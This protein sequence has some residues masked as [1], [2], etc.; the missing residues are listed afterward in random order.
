MTKNRIDSIFLLRLFAMLMVVL[1]HVTGQF[2]STLPFDS[3]AFQKYHFINRIV[4]IEAGIFI[5]ITGMVFFFNYMKKNLTWDVLK[6]YYKKRVTFI[7]VPYLIWAVFYEV[8]MYQIGFREVNIME[9]VDRILHGES[10][11]QLHFIF[12]IV[13]FYLVLPLFVYMAQK[14]NFFRKYM[15]AFG[16]GFELLYFY[17]NTTYEITTFHVF[18]N[19]IGTFLLGA[20]IGT[21]YNEMRQKIRSYSSVLLFIAATVAGLAT[22]YLHYDMYML[23]ESTLPGITYKFVNL[24]YMVTGSYLIFRLAELASEKMP[25]RLFGAVKN[26]A[27]YSFGFYLLHPVVLREVAKFIPADPSYM[28]HLQMGLRYVS[29]VIFCYLIIWTVHKFVPGA[30]AIFGKLPK[31]ASFVVPKQSEQKVTM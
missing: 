3:G 31:K 10:Y 6:D 21:Y 5:M 17:L 15:W 29:T 13:Q 12:L 1:V 30:S 16:F 28:F 27:V 20:W 19:S 4:R 8:Y 22:V 24:I 14:L 9:S 2:Q 25:N 7:L 23:N 11:Y 26:V 18:L